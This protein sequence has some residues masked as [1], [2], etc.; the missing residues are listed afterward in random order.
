MRKQLLKKLLCILG[1]LFIT[2]PAWSAVPSTLLPNDGSWNPTPVTA[3][4]ENPLLEVD[5]I[6]AQ[7]G[8]GGGQQGEECVSGQHEP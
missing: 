6:L 4:D 3:D 1:M 5:L 2:F 7:G 8:G